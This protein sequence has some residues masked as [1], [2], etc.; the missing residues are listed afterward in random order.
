[1]SV[2]SLTSDLRALESNL[3]VGKKIQVNSPKIGE[4]H[5]LFYTLPAVDAIPIYSF[6]NEKEESF[7]FDILSIPYFLQDAGI[8][9]NNENDFP[10]RNQSKMLYQIHS[11][12]GDS[13]LLH[14]GLTQWAIEEG[15]IG[16]EASFIMK[17]DLVVSDEESIDYLERTYWVPGSSEDRMGFTKF[18]HGIPELVWNEP[19][20]FRYTFNSHD[21]V[22]SE[23]IS[24]E[25]ATIYRTLSFGWILRL[26][27]SRD[28]L[29]FAKW[30]DSGAVR[31]LVE[32]MSD[33]E[34]LQAQQI[35]MNAKY[36]ENKKEI[37][38]K[39]INAIRQ[40][41]RRNAFLFVSRCLVLAIAPVGLVWGM[42]SIATSGLA[43]DTIKDGSSIAKVV[44]SSLVPYGEFGL[45]N[46][47]ITI[48]RKQSTLTPQATVSINLGLGKNNPAPHT[49]S[50]GSNH[51]EGYGTTYA[52]SRNWC[53][54]VF[55]TEGGNHKIFTNKGY[56]SKLSDCPTAEER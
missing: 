50:I 35:L 7:T 44:E 48:V 5:S 42:V 38:K 25:D 33:K 39:P 54:A 41:K 24:E 6:V 43:R 29:G 23:Y 46:G 14:F 12:H 1:M 13:S 18:P 51:L 19:N 2:A 56:R 22:R 4:G 30:D 45:K 36:F 53:I 8:C 52:N 17:K 21:T 28:V 11:P 47:K 26:V 27:G 32:A 15:N 49:V 37:I 3:R 20:L 34:A 31:G 40:E 9:R 16:I 55:D 10:Y